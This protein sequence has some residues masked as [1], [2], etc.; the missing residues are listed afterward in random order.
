[1]CVCVLILLGILRLV[2]A[3][4]SPHL[5]RNIP[6]VPRHVPRGEEPPWRGRSVPPFHIYGILDNHIISRHSSSMP[7]RNGERKRERERERERWGFSYLD[8]SIFL[9]FFPS[10]GF[11]RR[12]AH[13]PTPLLNSASS[14]R[15]I[16]IRELNE[17]RAFQF[18]SRR[19][20]RI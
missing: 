8:A 16:E 17:N 5:P 7:E 19:C 9:I 11:Y 6:F 18:I 12:V 10:L 13:R 14:D 15:L 1:M 20:G 4:S 3:R 2:V